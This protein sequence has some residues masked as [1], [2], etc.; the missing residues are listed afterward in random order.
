MTRCHIHVVHLHTYIIHRVTS[1]H[2]LS[3][4]NHRK[5]ERWFQLYRATAVGSVGGRQSGARLKHSFN[6]HGAQRPVFWH[7]DNSAPFGP[8]TRLIPCDHHRHWQPIPLPKTS[9]SIYRLDADISVSARRLR[10]SPND[11]LTS[12][13]QQR[14]GC[15]TLGDLQRLTEKT[16]C[17]SV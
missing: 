3:P 16:T 13:P 6:L 15:R 14:F 5:I 17:H 8:A 7:F 12:Y 2:I 11:L 1:G 9:Y 4:S 10:G